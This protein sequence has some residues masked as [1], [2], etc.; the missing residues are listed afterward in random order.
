M[1][2]ATLPQTDSPSYSALQKVLHSMDASGR[3]DSFEKLMACIIAYLTGEPVNV[4]KSGTQLG[5]ALNIKATIAIQAK[6]YLE[7]TALN[8]NE[9][10]GELRAIIR[11]APQLEVYV[12]GATRSAQDNPRLLEIEAETSVSIVV[13]DWNEPD[14]PVLGQLCA[15]CWDAIRHVKP[16]DSLLSTDWADWFR[17]EADKPAVMAAAASV[18]R[19]L[20]EEPILQSRL[21]S[22]SRKHLQKQ[23]FPNAREKQ[24]GAGFNQIDLAQAI[25]REANSQLQKWWDEAKSSSSAIVC[26]QEG[27]GK[28]W[29]TAAFV[30]QVATSSDHP[31]C[32]LDSRDWSTCSDLKSI[33]EQCFRYLVDDRSLPRLV[34]KAVNKWQ[35]PLLIVL[36]GVNERDALESAKKILRDF[37]RLTDRNDHPPSHIRLL[38]TSR[39]RAA[40][41]LCAECKSL[42]RIT[43]AS[44]SNH[45]MSLILPRLKAGLTLEEI[46]PALLT[47]VARIPRYLP[48]C[49]R[50]LPELGGLEHITVELVLWHDL[51]LRLREDSQ[52]RKQLG[53]EDSGDAESVLSQLAQRCR[54]QLEIET[55]KLGEVFETDF[56]SIRHDLQELCWLSEARQGRPTA[57]VSPDHLRL[58]W[59]LYLRETL[60]AANP[61]AAEMEDSLQKALE[62]LAAEDNRIAAL[63]LCGRLSLTDAAGFGSEVQLKREALLRLWIK[64]RNITQVDEELSFW[65]ERDEFFYLALVENLLPELPSSDTREKLVVPVVRAWCGTP[66]DTLVAALTRWIQLIAGSPKRWL[67][68]DWPAYSEGSEVVIGGH[69]FPRTENEDHLCLTGAAITILSHRADQRMLR[70]L[71]LA[72]ATGEYSCRYSPPTPQVVAQIVA[73]AKGQWISNKA[74]FSLCGPLMRWSYGEAALLELQKLV[75]ENSAD[76]V[77][78]DGAQ[79]MAAF[80]K[81]E[82]VPAQLSLPPDCSYQVRLGPH[83]LEDLL[84]GRRLINLASDEETLKQVEW[85]GY[86]EAIGALALWDEVDW[87]PE[88]KVVL[89]NAI[90]SLLESAHSRH[91]HGSKMYFAWLARWDPRAAAAASARA[92]CDFR[93]NENTILPDDFA[94]RVF[95]HPEERTRVMSC[96]RTLL[97]HTPGDSHRTIPSWPGL[98]LALTLEGDEWLDWIPWLENKI[99]VR[100]SLDYLPAPEVLSLR[101]PM[102]VISWLHQHLLSIEFTSENTS[103]NGRATFLAHLASSKEL[104]NAELFEKV[105]QWLQQNQKGRSLH[106]MFRLWIAVAPDFAPLLRDAELLSLS[107]YFRHFIQNRWSHLIANGEAFT[108]DTSYERLVCFVPWDELGRFLLRHGRLDDFRRWGGDVIEAAK[109]CFEDPARIPLPTTRLQRRLNDAGRVASVGLPATVI[110]GRSFVSDST[111]WLAETKELS[112][113]DFLLT[114]QMEDAEQVKQRNEVWRNWFNDPSKDPGHQS[115]HW[116]F[117]SAKSEIMEWATR[118]TDEFISKAIPFLTDSKYFR[119]NLANHDDNLLSG[120][121]RNLT[122]AWFCIHP[123][124]ATEHCQKAPFDHVTELQYGFD[125]SYQELWHP[126]LLALPEHADKPRQELLEAT[127]DLEIAQLSWGALLSDAESLIF[128]LAQ[129]WAKAAHM[130]QRALAISI[131]AWI[132]SRDAL[133]LLQDLERQDVSKGVRQHAHWAIQVWKTEN[134]A[135][136]LFRRI[137]QQTERWLASVMLER[138]HPALSLA[139]KW[140]LPREMTPIL[141]DATISVDIRALLYSAC[142]HRQNSTGTHEKIWGRDLKDYWRGEKLDSHSKTLAPHWRYAGH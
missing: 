104:P 42:K 115:R 110:P 27:M 120:V 29:V 118:H 129:S 47:H 127:N 92:I 44:Y 35:K 58:G 59:A 93:F 25:S 91:L 69:R 1:P 84:G 116:L 112:S 67:E 81:M 14:S 26:G 96:L 21:A 2:S 70:P 68:L 31:V 65:L 137:S 80:L 55:S 98:Y 119:T 72:V 85:L 43:V 83:P 74:M 57:R 113:D 62:P 140:W 133:N 7:T 36:D 94:I 131:L 111:A 28:S 123:S 109:A 8:L 75:D 5:D 105:K 114:D 102:S 88:D 3:E 51:L 106:M 53:I 139:A 142:H 49:I 79:W 126:R 17:A 60:Q 11:Q 71:V 41:D 13:V 101:I 22:V 34:S 12:L 89:Q 56:R 6:R 138:L 99:S 108:P 24:A 103:E 50:L 73:G 134:Y 87:H 45:E 107:S 136:Q 9:I 82:S 63:R 95:P 128:G 39:V 135:K 100:L 52:I 77:L 66:S 4:A 61:T 15:V 18:I 90:P 38:F 30:N 10:E 40:D 16:F 48:T 141:A 97:E 37:Y 78:K 33:L 132:D 86:C 54:D 32:W 117:F 76:E 23:F 130:N 20:I 121:R 19:E 122:D 46:P 64:S 124:A 125:T